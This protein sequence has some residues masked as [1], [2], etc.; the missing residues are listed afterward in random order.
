[1]TIEDYFIALVT[2]AVL[3]TF[4]LPSIKNIKIEECPLMK[5]YLLSEGEGGRN[6][7]VAGLYSCLGSS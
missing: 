7:V 2:I 5:R 1:M 4:T 6:E 3:S